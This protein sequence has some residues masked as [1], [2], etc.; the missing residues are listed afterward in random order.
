MFGNMGGLGGLG[1]GNIDQIRQQIMQ[2]PEMLQQALDNPLVQSITSNPEMMQSIMMQNPQMQQLVER[3]PEISHLLNNPELMR[4]TMQMM[5]NPAMMQEMMRNQDRAMSNLE[6]IPGGF[7]A[8]RRLYTDVQEPMMNAAD[9]QMR[10]QFG[11]NR[12]AESGS[13]PENPQRGTENL[14]PL[15]NPWGGPGAQSTSSTTSTPTNPFN[16]FSSNAS[17]SSTTSSGSTTR[18]AAAPG[19]QSMFQ[20]MQSN[21]QLTASMTQSPFFPT[22]YATDGAKPTDVAINDAK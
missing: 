5:R 20:Q 12:T 17:Q 16:L 8:L 3:N 13:T 2:N 22:S 7:N 14:D 19:I 18:P 6:S 10:S 1:V 11:Q 21:P 4:Q 15:P 9:E